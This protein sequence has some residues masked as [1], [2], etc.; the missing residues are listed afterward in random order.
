MNNCNIIFKGEGYCFFDEKLI[1][2][3]IYA[4][5]N[6]KIKNE[7][8]EIF[9]TF[10]M[11]SQISAEKV[12]TATSDTE[13]IGQKR[14][15]RKKSKNAGGGGAEFLV[16]RSKIVENVWKQFIKDDKKIRKNN[17][18][19]AGENNK[20]AREA[21]AKVKDFEWIEK[22]SKID[23]N[24]LD[25]VEIV[26][27]ESYKIVTNKLKLFKNGCDKCIRINFDNEEFVIPAEAEFCPGQLESVKH[28]DYGKKFF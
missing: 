16:E 26:E 4:S 17:N 25:T 15:K 12:V 28:L 22:L 19:K 23:S 11:D 27:N 18:E 8:Y 13:I 20:I 10:K 5:S 7:F 1:W 21:A 24:N 3:N 2:N 6:L 14:R 9:D